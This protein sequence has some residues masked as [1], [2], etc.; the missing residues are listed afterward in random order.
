VG[1]GGIA[2]IPAVGT[3]GGNV[4]PVLVR[5]NI[6]PPGPGVRGW[7]SLREKVLDAEEEIGSGGGEVS[8]GR[9]ESGRFILPLV[10]GCRERLK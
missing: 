10:E 3:G 6:V 9:R 5:E 1:G 8:D 7:L 4:P 2:G